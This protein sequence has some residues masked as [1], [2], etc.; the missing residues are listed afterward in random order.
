VLTFLVAATYAGDAIVSLIRQNVGMT[1]LDISSCRLGSHVCNDLASAIA[2]NRS[3]QYLRLD[4]NPFGDGA[5]TRPMLCSQV[6]C[7][8]FGELTSFCLYLFLMTAVEIMKALKARML[9]GSLHKFSMDN[10]C[11]DPIKRNIEYDHNCPSGYYKL[12]LADAKDRE[13]CKKLLAECKTRRQ[14]IFRNEKIDERRISLTKAIV[15]GGYDGNW[16][17]WEVSCRREAECWQLPKL[18]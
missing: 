6:S 7:L 2:A 14:D 8:I 5:G 4:G 16:K 18:H 10:C 3:M 15:C 11:F 13:I 12:D 17:G 1:D 9:D